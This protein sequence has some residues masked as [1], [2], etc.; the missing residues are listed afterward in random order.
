MFLRSKNVEFNSKQLL[1]C[2][3][4]CLELLVKVD[5]HEILH[6]LMYNMTLF[7]KIYFSRYYRAGQGKKGPGGA[8]IWVPP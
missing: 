3:S 5:C 1:N 2:W 6:L 7:G 8:L 4:F